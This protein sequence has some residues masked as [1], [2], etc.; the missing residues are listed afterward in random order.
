MRLIVRAAA[1][2]RTQE[3]GVSGEADCRERLAGA[4]HDTTQTL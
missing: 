1:G 4:Q 2:G 3:A